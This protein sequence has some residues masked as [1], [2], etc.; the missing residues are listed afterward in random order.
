M[1]RSKLGI[2]KEQTDPTEAGAGL[3][4]GESL[5]RDSGRGLEFSQVHQG[6]LKSCKQETDR[7]SAL[8]PHGREEC[9]VPKQERGE[10]TGK[11]GWWLQM[12]L[13]KL[14]DGLIEGWS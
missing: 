1:E 12:E 8:Q 10:G 9:G 7:I 13:T 6:T 14:A 4:E 2:T 5:R 11:R 3:R